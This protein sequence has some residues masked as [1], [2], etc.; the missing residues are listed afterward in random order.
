M[1][2]NEFLDALEAAS[3]TAHLTKEE[4]HDKIDEATKAD[5]H[6]DKEIAERIIGELRLR[7]SAGAEG[8]KYG[9][10]RAL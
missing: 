2:L 3:L 1:L 8:E 10:S 9:V 7:S 6:I 4:C 5:G